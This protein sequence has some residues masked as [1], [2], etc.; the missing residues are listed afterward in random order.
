MGNIIVAG[1]VSSGADL[2]DAFYSL[3]INAFAHQTSG[4]VTAIT[5]GTDYA[6]LSVKPPST[7][8]PPKIIIPP[9]TVGGG[10]WVPPA[11]LGRP[12]VNSVVAA[13]FAATVAGTTSGGDIDLVWA[14]DNC[15][16]IS[17]DI[18]L[19]L[20]SG[21]PRGAMYTGQYYAK[22]LTSWLIATSAD[23]I[24]WTT[25]DLGRGYMPTVTGHGSVLVAATSNGLYVSTDGGVTWTLKISDY[26]YASCYGGGVFAVSGTR[27]NYTS[28]DGGIW[29]TATDTLTVPG[30]G[31]TYQ[32]YWMIYDGT[33]F[34]AT[35][36]QSSAIVTSTNGAQW[37]IHWL[38]SPGAWFSMGFNGSKYVMQTRQNPSGWYQPDVNNSG[39]YFWYAYSVSTDGASTWQ[40]R[41]AATAWPGT[42]YSPVLAKDG[43]FYRQGVPGTGYYTST[44]GSTWVNHPAT[45][46]TTVHIT[47]ADIDA[48]NALHAGEGI[49]A[50]LGGPSDLVTGALVDTIAPPIL[51]VVAGGFVSSAAPPV[52]QQWLG[53]YDELAVPPQPFVSDASAVEHIS[54]VV[55]PPANLADGT[56]LKHIGH[57]VSAEG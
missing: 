45:V 21:W 24:T 2:L 12:G 28:T 22:V 48:F 14:P 6:T 11:T 43:T 33:K 25:S 32:S 37:T 47:Q 9:T 1:G 5:V 15:T 50:S 52:P 40:Q 36:S 56:A 30:V 49:T 35:S 31:G 42:W 16:L 23:G 53:S 27:G 54:S 51:T 39:T 46:S 41:T 57:A 29:Y 7:Y 26:C 38:D 17:K 20:P 10:P 18:A 44:D 19:T 55:L 13:T 4:T 34:C 3:W 8:K